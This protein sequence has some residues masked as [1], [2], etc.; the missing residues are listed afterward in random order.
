MKVNPKKH[1]GQHFLADKN[2]SKK[3]ADSIEY[4]G[5]NNVLE[6][7]PGT[8]ALT[9]FLLEQDNKLK[10]IDL[11][12]ESIEYLH[13]KHPERKKDIIFGDFLKMDCKEYFE[14]EFIVTGNFPYNISSQ[15]MFKVVENRDQITQVVGMFQKEVAERIA[16]K[17]GSKTYGILSIIVQAYYEVE[18]LFTVSENVFIPPPKV[19][20][21]VIRVKRKENYELGCDEQLFIKVV[22]AT[23]NQR[24][25]TIHNGLK[26]LNLGKP[27]PEKFAGKR[28]EQLSVAEFVELTKLLSD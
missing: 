13:M 19:K 12:N 14:D 11:D 17:E 18:Y 5:V 9:E 16:E 2:I 3:I 24:R 27:T 28:P 7:G 4:N 1:L 23:F 15:I 20:S 10:L 26:K 8:G 6:I 25:K 21:G 22:K